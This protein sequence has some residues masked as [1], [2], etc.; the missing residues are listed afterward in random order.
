MLAGTTAAAAERRHASGY[1]L[2]FDREEFLKLVNLAE[3]SIVYKRGKNHFFAFDGFVMYS[4]KCGDGDF[5][6]TIID[7]VEFSNSSWDT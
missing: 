4:Q 3:P 1:R 6:A 5:K 7:A 2:K